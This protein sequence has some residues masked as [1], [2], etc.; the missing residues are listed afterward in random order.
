[1][2]KFE[3]VAVRYARLSQL[4]TIRNLSKNQMISPSAISRFETNHYHLDKTYIIDLFRT[5]NIDYHQYYKTNPSFFL[6]CHSI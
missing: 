4:L 3:N 2:E 1:M 6:R 5:L